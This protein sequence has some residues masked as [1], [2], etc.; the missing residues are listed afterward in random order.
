MKAT[1]KREVNIEQRVRFIL[2]CIK[3]IY[4]YPSLNEKETNLFLQTFN[5]PELY[6]DIPTPFSLTLRKIYQKNL[7]MSSTQLLTM[8]K[9]I[10]NKGY[11]K[12][13]EYGEY[14]IPKA[15]KTLLE[16]DELTLIFKQEE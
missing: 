8:I 11:L 15:L 13:D 6:K 9:S 4:A 7:K 2:D 12:K 16:T 5:L 3:N 14:I 10:A 1:I